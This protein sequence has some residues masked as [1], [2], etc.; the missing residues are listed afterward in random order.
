MEE[1][2]KATD[3]IKSFIES[4]VKTQV[5]VVTENHYLYSFSLQPQKVQI[6]L[7][8]GQLDDLG[9]Y[10]VHNN[11]NSDQFKA[12]FGDIKFQIYINLGKAGLIPNISFSK[13]LLNEQREWIHGSLNYSAEP[14][15]GEIFYKGLVLL[16]QFLDE[17]IQNNDDI[18]E[19][20][21]EEANYISELIGF[22]DQY[23]VFKHPVM[24]D[25]PL[26]YFKAAAIVVLIGIEGEK[27]NL[28]IQRLIKKK[29]EEMSKIAMALRGSF[30]P[31]IELPPCMADYLSHYQDSSLVENKDQ[32]ESSQVGQSLE[33]QDK[34]DDLTDLFTQGFIDKKLQSI[35]DDAVKKE[36][37]VSIIMCDVDYFKK[38]NDRYGHQTG[39]FNAWLFKP[40]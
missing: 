28:R 15:L 11:T 5:F 2:A 39:S 31:V 16:K 7:N 34:K 25:K 17:V 32:K 23:R 30:F 24:N 6:I 8:R 19:E 38:V 14:W 37:P 27:K 22:F 3:Y 35:I 4:L 13:E 33:A 40:I 1:F 18:A 10:L 12:F 20:L 36:L 26:S 9:H 29:D 21:A